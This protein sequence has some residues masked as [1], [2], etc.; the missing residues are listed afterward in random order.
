[1]CGIWESPTEPEKEI[2]AKELE[3]LPKLKF[4]NITG[5]EPF[6]RDDLEDIVE[7]LFTKVP[8]IVISTSGYWTEKTIKLAERFPNIGIRVS[9]EGMEQ[10]NNFLRGR[11]DGYERGLKTLKLLHEMRVKDIGFGQT[12]SNH[13][14]NDLIPLYK[15]GRTM[16]FEFATAAFH[17]GYYFHKFDNQISNKDELCKNIGELINC[18]LKEKK[19]KS[20]FR[21]YFNHG[22]INYIKGNKRLLPCE[23]GTANFFIDPYGEVYPCNAL[24]E[25]YWKKSMGNIREGK[26]FNEIWNSP[27]A[28]EVRKCVKN[29]SK[30]CWMMGT[31]A[32]VMKKYVWK[33]MPWVAWNKG[34]SLFQGG[35]LGDC[36]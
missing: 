19:P 8:R 30:N 36:F 17:N 12:L 1:M 35:G 25:K 7:V 20:W 22:L 24:E 29:C 6:L 9:I 15:L 2:K 33:V 23:A 11:E 14:S 26:S 34:R 16:N 3:I 28:S 27:E 21:A 4:A 13:N 5:G 18:L 10:T 31:V 32:P